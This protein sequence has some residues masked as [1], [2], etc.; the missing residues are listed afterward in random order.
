M[1]L[2]DDVATYL[3][4]QSTAFTILSAS[5]GNLAKQVML[6][7][8]PNPDTL[9]VLYETQGSPN[10]YTF[11]TA[12]G[13]ARVAI[14]RPSFQILNRSTSYQTAR[15]RSQ[16]AYTILDGLAGQNLP[17]A[18]G[19]LYLEIVAAQAPFFVQRDDNERYIVSTN[20][21]VMKAV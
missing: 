4:A 2:L 12:T 18:T 5:S 7:S 15:T 19:T 8:T 17:T 1:P 11:S 16:T 20:F 6:D 21:T 10:D 13:G 3:D 14:E 9:T